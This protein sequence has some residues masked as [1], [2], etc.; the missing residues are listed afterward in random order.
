[1]KIKIKYTT[2]YNIGYVYMKRCGKLLTI[3]EELLNLGDGYLLYYCLF[4]MVKSFFF[5]IK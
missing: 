3:F 5:I 1:M 4:L 2:I